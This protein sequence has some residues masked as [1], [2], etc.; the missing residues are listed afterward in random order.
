MKLT[1]L[2]AALLAGGMSFSA[3]AHEFWIQPQSFRPELGKNIGIQL[4]VGDGFPGE[5][6]PR[7][8][9]KLEKFVV[10]GSIG[11]VAIPGFDGRDPAGVHRFERAGVQVLGYRSKDTRIEMPGTKFDDYLKQEGLHEIIAA[12][13]ERGQTGTDTVEN[14]SRCAK[15]LVRAGEN[16]ADDPGHTRVLGLT[17]E[18]V[19]EENPYAKSPGESLKVRFLYE[20]APRANQQ[21]TVRHSEDLG[22]WQVLRT[23]EQGFAM[24][25]LPKPGVYLLNGVVMREGQPGSGVDWQSVWSSLTFEVVASGGADAKQASGTPVTPAQTGASAESRR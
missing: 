5:V 9:T 22:M 21:I 10:A 19:T 8:P 17:A 23:D 16:V 11:A 3:A 24:V 12:R 6:R 20:G 15:A 7:D 2:F 1:G 25:A 18:M 14:F 4:R 13:K